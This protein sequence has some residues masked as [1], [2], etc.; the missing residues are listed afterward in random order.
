MTMAWKQILKADPTEWLL[1]RG[2]PSVRF[3]ALQDL[4]GREP[5]NPEVKEAQ[6]AVMDSPPVRAILDAQQPEGH[7]V[8]REDMYLPKYTAT[9]H[10]LLILAELGARRTAAIERGL[11]HIFEFQRDSGHFLTSLPKTAKGRASVVKDGC[12]LDANV[13]YYM[14]HFGYL[15]DPR[16]VRLLDFIVDY[17]SMEDAGWRCR[18]FPINPDAVFPVNCYMGAVKTLRALSKIPPD[19]RS[20]GM[21]AVIER[22]V[23]NILENGVYRYL[24]NPDGTRKEKAGWKRFGFPLF[25]QSDALEALDT[26]TRLGVRDGR[27]EDSVRLV[28]EAQGDDGRW[29]LKHTFNGKMWADIDVKHQP[30]K[31]VTLRAMRM[32]RRYYEK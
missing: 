13:L 31:W 14:S 7:W 21:E 27:M 28:L 22:E 32:L 2:D 1:E 19:E 26:L 9:T 24:R 29:A 3:W 20:E 4:E 17:H 16:V 30:S 11:E 25:Y 12:C 15:D 23:E 10:S 6:D 18:A 5:D 8:H